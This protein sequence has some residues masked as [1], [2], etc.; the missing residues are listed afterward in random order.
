VNKTFT[1]VLHER[2]AQGA[3]DP[4]HMGIAD[5]FGQRHVL[6]RRL[7]APGKQVMGLQGAS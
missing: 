4:K 2:E 1:S 7:L 5:V 6:V 3:T